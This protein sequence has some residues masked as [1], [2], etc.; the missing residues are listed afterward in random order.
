LTA[1]YLR[2]AVTSPHV[3][4]PER[5]RASLA[6]RYAV[7][8]E[9]GRGGM[10]VVYLARDLRHDRPVALKILLPGLAL[11]SG[12]ERFQREILLAARLQHP[13]ILT[14]LDSGVAGEPG[15]EQLW[16]TMPFVDGESLY[17]RLNRVRQL[18][19][20]EA[21][22]I[23]TEAARALAYAHEQGVVHR[24]VKPENIL[25]TRDGTTLVCD[26]GIARALGEGDEPR[27]TRTGTQVGSPFY[28]SPEQTNDGEVDGR[29]DQFALAAVV[30]EMLT[31]EPPF[32]GR[33]L[34]AVI[35]KRLSNP[36][37]SAR[38]LRDTVPPQVDAAIRKAM[39]RAPDDRFATVTQFAQALMT[40]GSP[41]A[42]A[43]AE[44]EPLGVS[45]APPATPVPAGG[46]RRV[47]GGVIALA[48]VL[49]AV[50]ALFAWRR[51]HGPPPLRPDRGVRVVAVLP[52]DNLGDS[53]DSYFADGVADE[54]RTK[55]AQVA[56]LEVI[57][58]GSSVEYRHSSRRPADVARELGADYLLTGTVR[59]EK[60]AAASRVRVTPELVDARRGAAAR[61]R[62]AQQFDA[63]LT[64]VFQVQA[65]IAGKVADA[66]GVALADSARR[67]IAA[68]PT[69]SLEAWDAFLQ[70][71]AAS[72]QMK[73]DQ[74]SLRR[75]I[76]FYERAIA[77]DSGFVQAWGELSR[78]R[79]SLYSNGVPDPALGAQ[80][81]AAAERARSLG[82]GD[83]TV[84]LALGDY[85]GAV[86]PVDNA[87]A[88]AEYETGLRLAPDN[89][90]LLGSVVS[91]RTGLGQWDGVTAPLAR[92]AQL[93]PRSA[94]VARRQATVLLFLRQYPAADSAADR[95]LALAPANPGIISIK[96]LLAVARGDLDSA[97]AV[98]RAAAARIDP[99][100][101]Y[102]F[103]AAYQDMYWV[104]DD[105]QQRQVLAAPPG[106]FDE[107]SAS[108]AL[109][110]TGLYHLHQDR[111]ETRRWA[112]SARRAVERQ[113]RAAPEDWQ[114]HGLLG[115]ALAYLGEGEAAV[116]EGRRGVDLMPISRDGYFG[117]Y[118]QLQLARI[119]L[120]TGRPGLALDH[121]EPLVRVPFY[122]SPAWLRLDPTFEPLRAEP[123]FQRLVEGR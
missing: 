120:L 110:R 85:Y 2:F 33:T 116:R 16:Y 57:A 91:A 56:G 97:R 15:A 118:A 50:A 89:V 77:L 11:R 54:I 19:L 100:V 1:A 105:A 106:A 10:G 99:G 61:T 104:L 14:V 47:R 52:F 69:A 27:L 76:R 79:T 94:T 17:A 51:A 4:L 71:E 86:N 93:D 108:W 46:P 72:L 101:L 8:R 66:L 36:T 60:A 78:T 73:G 121:L 30:F 59:W 7:E 75:A 112:D 70:G 96:L 68:P 102:P 35:A 117:P 44:P 123:R 12:A 103:L 90:D 45:A 111:A 74:A 95:A 29:T 107:D 122:L 62:W 63:S 40:P 24:D 20:D 43:P 32:A 38:A 119:Y 9:L 88:V 55:L 48:L 34:E 82:P 81:L 3:D 37:P 22:R 41:A 23:A 65:D 83:P 42:S 13:H 6:G 21:L 67:A 28:M 39:A 84:Y 53:A 31:G 109:V 25:L 87:R 64:D 5:L 115:L 80:A 26:F 18:P 113:L 114:R 49:L 98:I 58:R 92:A